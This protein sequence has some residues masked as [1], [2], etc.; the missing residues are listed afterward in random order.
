[1]VEGS[2]EHGL[3]RNRVSQHSERR[4]QIRTESL[5]FFG[6]IINR[7]KIP[8]LYVQDVACSPLLRQCKQVSKETDESRWRWTH[9]HHDR[10]PHRKRR[11]ARVA[12]T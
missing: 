1:M 11:G 2:H 5:G 6:C 4:C 3:L 12:I 7:A 9:P 8:D 10:Q